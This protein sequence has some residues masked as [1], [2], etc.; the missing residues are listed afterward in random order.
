MYKSTEET[1]AKLKSLNL[2][3]YFKS[4]YNTNPITIKYNNNIVDEVKF[5]ISRLGQEEKIVFK[6]FI[7]SDINQ[8]V[9]CVLKYKNKKLEISS[10]AEFQME[11]NLYVENEIVKNYDTVYFNGTLTLSFSKEWLE[12]HILDGAHLDT[13]VNWHKPNF[14]TEKTFCIGDS[15]TF[16]QGVNKEDSWP[17][18][19]NEK[20]YNFGSKGLSH[21]GCLKNVEYIL[22]NSKYVKQI[23]CLLPDATRKLLHFEF[24]GHKGSIPISVNSNW[25]LPEEYNQEIELIKKFIF[26]KELIVNDWINSCNKIIELCEKQNIKCWLTTWAK[27]LHNLIPIRYKLPVFP[28]IDTFVER[29]NDNLHPHRKHYELFANSIKSHIDNI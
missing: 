22:K 28:P 6:G 18:L 29:A 21:D 1:T 11:D 10:I 12:Y 17:Y 27:D 26:D 4:S 3:L 16:G 9:S 15:F 2:V 19:L 23:I 13:F 20:Y 5:K 25:E 7:P 8:K 24:L 14:N